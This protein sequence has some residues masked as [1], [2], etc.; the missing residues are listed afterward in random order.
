MF[1]TENLQMTI[2]AFAVNVR[3]GN[4]EHTHVCTATF[5]LPLDYELAREIS[6]TVARDLYVKVQRNGE[7]AWVPKPEMTNVRLS[8]LENG[9]YT[10]EL[11]HHPEIAPALR[12]RI[13][14]VRIKGIG[15]SKG[16]TPNGALW[17]L[18]FGIG[19]DVEDFDHPLRL[20]KSLKLA[21]FVTF[22]EEQPNLPGTKPEVTTESEGDDTGGDPGMEL[23]R[24]GPQGLTRVVDGEVVESGEATDAEPQEGD[25]PEPSADAA[26]DDERDASGGVGADVSF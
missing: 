19:F 24:I 12:D 1:Q 16:E 15:V 11:R 23:V 9:P 22:I 5:Q 17:T 14:H 3:T 21:A 13:P 7:D 2:T 25:E 18:A 6:E 8:L 20:M 26:A 4:D 10:L